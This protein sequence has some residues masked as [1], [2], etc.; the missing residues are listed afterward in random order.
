MALVQNH[1]PL[2]LKLYWRL[3]DDILFLER[4]PGERMPT[5]EELHDRYG[6]SQSTVHKALALLEKDGLITKKRARGIYI[7]PEVRAQH[8]EK[9]FTPESLKAELNT[10]DFRLLSEGWIK[11]T[12]SLENLFSGQ[13]EVFKQNRL[14]R[15]QALMVH[16]QEPRRKIF[17]STYLPAWAVAAVPLSVITKDPFDSI[18]QLGPFKTERI[19]RISRPWICNLEMAE[20]LNVLEGTALFRRLFLYY[21]EDHRLL[22]VCDYVATSHATYQE[23]KIDWG[24]NKRKLKE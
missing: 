4:L 15:F 1:I 13:E 22:A 21:T 17:L 20:R 3:R 16:R 19:V 7:N 14:Y 2:S 11:K 12:R 23:T 18:L 10:F 8:W 5:V 9:T 24:K 6:V